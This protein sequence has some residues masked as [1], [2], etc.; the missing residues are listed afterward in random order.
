M[1]WLIELF[2]KCLMFLHILRHFLIVIKVTIHFFFLI[3]HGLLL[4]FY[5][6][7]FLGLMRI[8]WSKDFA[9]LIDWWIHLLRRTFVNNILDSIII[10]GLNFDRHIVSSRWH[11]S[12]RV[13]I[14]WN[15]VNTWIVRALNFGLLGY[16]VLSVIK[17]IWLGM[18]AEVWLLTNIV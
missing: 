18:M 17:W 9:H 13:M 6:V 12:L 2:Y 11:S 3:L 5:H 16:L 14:V 15:G 10:D 7:L 4:L 8:K 1:H